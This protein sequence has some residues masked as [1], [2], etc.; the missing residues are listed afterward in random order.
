MASTRVNDEFQTITPQIIVRGVA[1]AVEFYK[2]ALDAH[3]LYRNM[4]PDG[5]SVMHCEMLLGN[6]R[7]LMHD[8]FP[9]H[10]NVSPLTLGGTPVRLHLYVENVDSAFQRAVE[11]GAEVLM[12]VQ[13]C[14][15]GDRYGM[16]KDPFGHVWSMATPLEDLSPDQ[17]HER[18]EAYVAEVKGI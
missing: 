9:E 12:P 14:F 13:D 4:A 3:E 15:W 7:F 6:S 18:A 11:A 17:T 8:E 2:K 16:L 5:A 10:G 1:E